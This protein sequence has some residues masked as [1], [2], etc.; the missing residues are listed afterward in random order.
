VRTLVSDDETLVEYLNELANASMS[1]A[2]D[3]FAIPETLDREAQISFLNH[4]SD[5]DAAAV[6]ADLHLPSNHPG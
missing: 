3:P 6:R 2:Q 5:F 4:K 1:N